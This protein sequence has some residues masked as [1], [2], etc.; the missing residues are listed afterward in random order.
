MREKKMKERQRAIEQKE[1]LHFKLLNLIF[2]GLC[3]NTID[4]EDRREIRRQKLLRKKSGGDMDIYLQM[5][6]E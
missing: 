3:R 2:C 5:D 6:K 1:Q 4:Y